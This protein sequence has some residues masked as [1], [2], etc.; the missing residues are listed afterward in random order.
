MGVPVVAHQPGGDPAA[1]VFDAVQ[2]ALAKGS[3]LVIADTAGRMHTK[4]NL[5]EE[6]KKIT[7]IVE[8]QASNYVIKKILVLD[9]TTGQNGIQ[10][11]EIFHEAVGVDAIVLTKYDSLSKGGIAIT[12]AR[13]LGIPFAF[14]GVGEK[15][16]DIKKF[17]VDSFVDRI[18]SE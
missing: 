5:I 11:A 14:V 15:Y 2:S 1:V 17:D 8:K 6:L 10:Q 4:T 13:R 16:S 9:S 12:I 18:L 3:D 7:R